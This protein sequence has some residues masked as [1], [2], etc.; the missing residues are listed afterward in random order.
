[1]STKLDE[2]RRLARERLAAPRERLVTVTPVYDEAFYEITRLLNEGV[3]DYE[4]GEFD[5]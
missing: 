2:L 5:E 1:M 4:D 3:G